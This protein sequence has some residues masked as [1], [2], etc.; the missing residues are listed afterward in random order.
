MRRFT[1]LDLRKHSSGQV[2]EI[3]GTRPSWPL[4]L[5]HAALASRGYVVDTAESACSLPHLRAL[6]AQDS[7][8]LD[9]PPSVGTETPTESTVPARPTNGEIIWID[10]CRC[11]D[12]YCGRGW[13]ATVATAADGVAAGVADGGRPA[14]EPD[15]AGPGA[16]AGLLA[17]L[18]VPWQADDLDRSPYLDGVSPAHE[19]TQVGISL[20]AENADGTFADRPATLL[21]AE[22]SWLRSQEEMPSSPV[23]LHGLSGSVEDVRRRLVSFA[24]LAG[25]AAIAD[26]TATPCWS[27]TL[28]ATLIDEAGVRAVAELTEAAG[29]VQIRVTGIS[30]AAQ[31][32]GLLALGRH[33]ALE[34]DLRALGPGDVQRVAAKAGGQ[35]VTLR[36]GTT[37]DGL[38]SGELLTLAP[39][40]LLDEPGSAEHIQ[41]I[42]GRLGR[43]ATGG[44]APV[45]GDERPAPT[46][47]PAAGAGSGPGSGPE[48]I[49]LASAEHLTAV[50]DPDT[51][52]ADFQTL[53]FTPAD[54]GTPVPAAVVGSL[55]RYAGS[56]T[57]PGD[58]LL[59]GDDFF[60][61]TFD[62]ASGAYL[63]LVGPT[64]LRITSEIDYSVFL[65]DA[66]AARS[67]GDFPEHLLHPLVQLADSCALGTLHPCAGRLGR[68]LFVA[69]DGTVRPAPGGAI[70]GHLTTAGFQP[71]E[72][73]FSGHAEI[74]DGVPADDPCL[75]EVVPAEVSSQARQ[76][77]P[78][79]SR[80]LWS[81][82]ALRRAQREGIKRPTV[83]GF[84]GRL[85]EAL[86][87]ELADVDAPN[88]PLIVADRS[89]ALLVTAGDL[90]VFRISP[91]AAAMVEI[92]LVVGSGERAVELACGHTRAS[93]DTVRSGFAT[94]IATFARSGVDLAGIAGIAARSAARDAVAVVATATPGS[95]R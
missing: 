80:F 79:L 3:L 44:R 2:T 88:A 62:Y 57:E 94:L 86:A 64:L 73:A 17:R 82:D 32:I 19:V 77:R 25:L 60:L 89:A 45:D 5:V 71:L 34:L 74:L 95:S 42:S 78:W 26:G 61:Q 63:S 90:R 47:D 13:R 67:R 37:E 22:L 40:L 72:H 20:V 16:L 92:L 38:M 1:L 23:P 28:A 46:A 43:W 11:D 18:S 14:D 10:R 93:A 24:S 55:V 21:A 39:G 87:G 83:S 84:G 58:D 49:V 85:V 4:R 50:T 36:A 6:V 12:A 41:A 48:E 51:G 56:A 15:G 30:G 53:V 27:A 35:R 31:A 8:G 69:A 33:I 54:P 59:I 68:R 65:E 9:N 91:A 7:D 29:I 66:D 76:V 70:F 81:I 52:L 75:A